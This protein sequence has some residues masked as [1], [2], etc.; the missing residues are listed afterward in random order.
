MQQ[1]ALYKATQ[2][3]PVYARRSA[4]TL[5]FYP[6][7]ATPAYST[8]TVN[9]NYVAKPTT[10]SWGYNITLGQA[11][12]NSATSVDFELHPSEETSLVF[13]IL[14][15]AGIMMEDPGLVNV[16]NQEEASKNQQELM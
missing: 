10:A 1:T 12:Y 8:S 14:E 9:C 11:T 5:Q 16:A 7:S 15:L 4:T 13:D 6:S 2:L 3:R